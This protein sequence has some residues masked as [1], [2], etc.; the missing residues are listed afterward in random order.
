MLTPKTGPLLRQARRQPGVKPGDASPFYGF[1][2]TPAGGFG[3]IFLEPTSFQF[4]FKTV[5]PDSVKDLIIALLV[6]SS[7]F[8]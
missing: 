1:G 3:S 2:S 7:A 5:P 8:A 6:S 4:M